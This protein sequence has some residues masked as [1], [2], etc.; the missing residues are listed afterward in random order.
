MHLIICFSNTISIF[1][2]IEC[3]HRAATLLCI[4]YS[5]CFVLS[6]LKVQC[7]FGLWLIHTMVLQ[8]R[9][10]LIPTRIQWNLGI[11][12]LWNKSN[13]VYV[14]FGR[15]TFCLVYDLRLEYDLRACKN[16]LVKM[17]HNTTRYSCYFSCVSVS[18]LL[19]YS[20]RL[21]H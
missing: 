13:L 3:A 5:V 8:R 4:S 15:E 12:L 21:A 6:F 10:A 11:R 14:M 16:L 19:P 1:F 17:S 9:L 7:P 20:E 18:Q 2:N